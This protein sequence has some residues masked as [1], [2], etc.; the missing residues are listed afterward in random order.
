MLCLWYSQSCAG[1]VAELVGVADAV[2]VAGADVVAG[3]YLLW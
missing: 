1:T 2:A 3:G